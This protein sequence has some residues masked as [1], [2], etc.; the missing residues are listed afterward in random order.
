MPAHNG[1]SLVFSTDMR[2][3]TVGETLLLVLPWVRIRCYGGLYP[4]HILQD[5]LQGWPGAGIAVGLASRGIFYGPNKDGDP[6]W[7]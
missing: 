7:G 2:V 4:G 5:Q 3:L 6:S 1:W